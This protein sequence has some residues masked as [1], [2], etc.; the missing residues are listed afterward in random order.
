MQ[1]HLP[2]PLPDHR[3]WPLRAR[4]PRHALQA[5]GRDTRRTPHR[6]HLLRHPLPL[7]RDARSGRAH[8]CPLPQR[9]PARLHPRGLCHRTRVRGPPRRRAVEDERQAVRL[10]RQGRAC[11][12]RL[13]RAERRRRADGSSPLAGREAVVAGDS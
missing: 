3:L 12:A 2:Q 9:P 11:A 10:D 6:R 5:G 1:D 13:F 4:H 8:A 7:Q